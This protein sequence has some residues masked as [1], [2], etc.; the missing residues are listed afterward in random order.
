MNR[1][2]MIE[3][4]GRAM[5]LAARFT[6][7]K[8]AD[9]PMMQE[10]AL[11]M[12]NSDARKA[13]ERIQSFGFTSTPLPRDE[14]NDK[15]KIGAAPSHG[16]DGEKNKGPA[17]EGICLFLGGQRNHP[18]CIGID[19][20]RHR[21]MGLKPG[22]NSQYD[23]QGQMTLLRRN[24]LFLLS[25]DSEEKGKDGKTEKKERMVSLRHVTKDK[26]DRTPMKKPS[27]KGMSPEA[28][29]RVL[30]RAQED[31]LKKKEAYVHEGEQEKVNTE[32]RCTAKRIEL[33][34]GDKMVGHYDKASDTWELYGTGGNFKVIIAPDKVIGQYQ[35]SNKSFMVDS[36]HTHI[37]FGGNAIFV[38]AAGCW[39]TL[40]IEIKPD[41]TL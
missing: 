6:L 28:A 8:A 23:D 29:A 32:V 31:D 10:L 27:T 11:D 14:S 5:H 4:A 15:E 40:P 34:T 9:N 2:S 20:R 35:N 1:N 22:E 39:S 18:V 21:P 3:T 17:A 12:M 19:D 30:E 41:P 24:G 25:L 38:D 36:S 33:R 7:N 16:G 37:K 13:I 26:Q